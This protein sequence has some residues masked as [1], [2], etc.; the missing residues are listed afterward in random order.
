[1]ADIVSKEV[2]SRMMSGIKGKDTKPELLIRRGLHAKG[3][4]FR[5][6]TDKVPGKPDLLLPRYRT[7]LFVHGCFWHKHDCH[8]FKMPSTRTSFWRTK[9]AQN[10]RR[11]REVDQLLRESGW[12]TLTV[13][14]CALKGRRR[15]DFDLLISKISDWL[16]GD[17][18][19]GE[20]GG[21]N[22]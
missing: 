16:R 20:I 18:T 19:R 2:R 22:E 15:I 3:F 6:H 7:A 21:R 11:D 5:V 13:W 1:M 10:V 14:E 9:I 8:L 12:R 4:R 17:Q